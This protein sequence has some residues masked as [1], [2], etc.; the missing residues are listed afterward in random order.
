VRT[1]DA[2][3]VV[4]IAAV[5]G[6]GQV[7]AQVIRLDGISP[8]GR[9]LDTAAAEAIDSQSPDRAVSG[10]DPQPIGRRPRVGPVQ[11]DQ[12]CPGISRLGRGVDHHPIRDR[13]QRAGWLNR[14]GFAAG[15]RKHDHIGTSGQIGQRVGLCHGGAQGAFRKGSDHRPRVAVTIAQ[16]SVAAIAGRIDDKPVHR[17]H[18]RNVIQV[19]DVGTFLEIAVQLDGNGHLRRMDGIG[20]GVYRQIQRVRFPVDH[21]A[22]IVRF[23]VADLPPQGQ[24]MPLLSREAIRNGRLESD[25]S[26]LFRQVGIPVPPL[27]RAAAH[28]LPLQSPL[29]AFGIDPRIHR[30]LNRLNARRGGRVVAGRSAELEGERYFKVTCFGFLREQTI[31]IDVGV[32]VSARD[33]KPQRIAIQRHR[34][35]HIADIP[36]RIAFAIH[37]PVIREFLQMIDLRGRRVN[38]R[39]VAGHVRKEGHQ[40]PLDMRLA[41][42][43][44]GH[45]IVR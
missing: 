16:I 44:I 28:V 41:H 3:P 30:E 26:V 29:V 6:A 7:H 14:E 33:R 21:E 42:E 1:G 43:P 20:D 9:Q 15:D 11:F 36:R 5:G 12:R 23:F 25:P 10:R 35:R 34:R 22:L 24:R 39:I 4:Q 37:A 8:G 31:E 13:G 17:P 19:H 27:R 2:D 45:E 18:E 38:R 32:R 40:G